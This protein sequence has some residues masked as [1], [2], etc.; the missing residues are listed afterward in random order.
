MQDIIE[1]KQVEETGTLKQNS[2]QRGKLN[3]K[4]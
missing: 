1:A 4:I 2:Q 3:I